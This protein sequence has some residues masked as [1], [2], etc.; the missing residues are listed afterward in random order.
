MRKAFNS[1]V[2]NTIGV[3]SVDEYIKNTIVA[4]GKVIMPKQAVP[5][6]GYM[7]YCADSEGNIFGM[8]QKEGC[9]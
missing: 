9:T 3:S 5:G 8:M 1:G 4:G 7:A 2:I 6:I